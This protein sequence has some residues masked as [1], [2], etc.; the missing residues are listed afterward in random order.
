MTASCPSTPKR[1]FNVIWNF[2]HYVTS[3]TY[4]WYT[5][6]NAS[7]SVSLVLTLFVILGEYHV[8]SVIYFRVNFSFHCPHSTGSCKIILILTNFN[9]VVRE[10]FEKYQGHSKEYFFSDTL[11][12]SLWDLWPYDKASNSQGHDS[13]ILK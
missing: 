4:L 12:L 7:I 6:R 3:R 9:E 1:H 8:N 13:L 2:S 5:G 10:C 11:A